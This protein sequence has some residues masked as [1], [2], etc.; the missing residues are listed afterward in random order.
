MK[1]I[2]WGT[3][4]YAIPT[5]D[6]LIKDGNE[7][8]CVVTQPDKRRTRG[9]DKSPSPIKERAQEY[10]IPVITTSSIRKDVVT[11]E[12]IKSLNA[13]IF[14]VVAFGQ[15]LPKDILELPRLGCW[16]SHASLLPRW[17]GAAPIQWSI[18]KGD[19]ETGIDIMLMDE[20]LDTG[21]VLLEKRIDIDLLD[22]YSDLSQKLSN[23]SAESILE[24][25]NIIKS[26]GSFKLDFRN[27]LLNLKLQS[28]SSVEP[29]YAR[30]IVKA[31]KLINW[32]EPVL[33]VHK[34]IMGLYPNT[35]TLV[36]NKILKIEVTE[37][38]EPG[39]KLEKSLITNGLDLIKINKYK[40]PGTI[41]SFQKGFGLLIRCI[42]HPILIRKAKLQG[43]KSLESDSLIQ[44]LKLHEG[45]IINS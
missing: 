6:A 43:K 39:S 10:K 42:D 13:D 17:R 31:D 20:G 28:S 11:K 9:R 26:I 1:I 23:L 18:L 19:K 5:L 41:V 29:T 15:I 22:N 3:P 7:I 25:I 8:L 45:Y 33:T 4:K 2:F 32:A 36:N 38:I 34:R 40:E 27:K 44:Q 30:Q 24:A 21:P 14:I 37:P 16:N 35:F 12:K